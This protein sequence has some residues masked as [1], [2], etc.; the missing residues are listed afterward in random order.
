[1]KPN[2]ITLLAISTAVISCNNA[3]NNSSGNTA[4]GEQNST[5]IPL[6]L[7]M[8]YKYT[9]ADFNLQGKVKQITEYTYLQDE[10]PN[11]KPIE[12]EPYG[13]TPVKTIF[14][15]PQGLVTQINE[16]EQNEE[17]PYEKSNFVYDPQNRLILVKRTSPKSKSIAT[18]H[19]QYSPEGFLTSYTYKTN[20]GEEEAIKTTYETTSTPEGIKII[21]KDEDDLQYEI[22]Y[23]NH[24]KLLVK[25]VL[26]DCQ[27][28]KNI[29]EAV[30][31]YDANKRCKKETYKGLGSIYVRAYCSQGTA[32]CYY[33][34]YG[35]LTK[36]TLAE[37]PSNDKEDECLD[38]EV[39]DYTKEYS[40]DDQGNAI[41]VIVGMGADP[42][43]Q[44]YKIEYY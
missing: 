40:Y 4:E 26:Y 36:V 35:N 3:H 10:D 5:N 7:E 17:G 14:F 39:S 42:L 12:G 30:Y 9:W 20:D 15:N 38:A 1:M 41:R 16:Y 11:G 27:K 21:G 31:T 23:Y 22:K 44:T 8:N 34:K 37:T 13:S 29:G 32:S 6:V 43:I 25:R 28:K 19:Y 2:I 33:D 24:Q 18:E